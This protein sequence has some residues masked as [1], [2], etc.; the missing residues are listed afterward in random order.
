MYFMYTY[1][2]STE[3]ALRNDGSLY[4]SN[5]RCIYS[6][7]TSTSNNIGICWY[8][9]KTK[10]MLEYLHEAIPPFDWI[11]ESKTPLNSL[12]DIVHHRC[13]KRKSYE[14]IYNKLKL[15]YIQLDILSLF[16]ILINGIDNYFRYLLRIFQ[17][18]LTHSE[19][20]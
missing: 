13:Q 20:R 15:L 7:S 1:V 19:V 14:M 16:S 9:L 4:P 3:S 8:M 10:S 2:F 5:T 11:N 12:T 17:R 18:Q 6:Y